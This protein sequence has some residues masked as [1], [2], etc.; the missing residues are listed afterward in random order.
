MSCQH[1]HLREVVGNRAHEEIVNHL[2]DLPSLTM[3]V[4]I[5]KIINHFMIGSR[6]IL[7]PILVDNI[8]ICAYS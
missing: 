3:R 6:K 7:I 5:L 8:V 2:H 1:V 4:Y